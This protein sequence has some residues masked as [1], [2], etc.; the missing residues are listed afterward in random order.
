MG[1]KMVQQNSVILAVKSRV[2]A[3]QTLFA[4][5]PEETNDA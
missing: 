3:L 2:G 5:G 1:T 4:S